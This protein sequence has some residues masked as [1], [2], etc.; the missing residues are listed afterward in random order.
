MKTQGD[1]GNYNEFEITATDEKVNQY[2]PDGSSRF[3]KANFKYKV[4]IK[5]DNTV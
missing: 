5:D 2:M 4:V 1:F 3:T